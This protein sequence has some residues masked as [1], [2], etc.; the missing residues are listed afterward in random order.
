MSTKYRI[1]RLLTLNFIFPLYSTVTNPILSDAE[2][3]KESFE[4][5]IKVVAPCRKKFC[6][7]NGEKIDFIHEY[8]KIFEKIH[9]H[10]DCLEE[11]YGLVESKNDI[12]ASKKLEK[13][14][15]IQSIYTYISVGSDFQLQFSKT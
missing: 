14:Y 10:F 1:L 2:V 6:P 13:N 9:D 15:G 5:W 12:W 7:K 11:F 8:S 3:H 4:V